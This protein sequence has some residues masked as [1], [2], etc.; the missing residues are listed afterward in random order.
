MK[1]THLFG[2]P[3]ILLRFGDLIQISAN[4]YIFNKLR[5]LQF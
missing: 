5:Q 2:K 4:D 1:I 3:A